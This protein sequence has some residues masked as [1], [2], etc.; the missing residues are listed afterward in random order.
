MASPQ[1]EHG[2]TAIANE[3][4]DALS[5]YRIPGEKRQVLDYI[6]RMTYGYNRKQI[7]VSYSKISI[8][9]HLHRQAVKRSV[10]WLKDNLVLKI[11]PAGTK[12]STRIAQTFVFNK[13]YEEWKQIEKKKSGNKNST[14]FG[15]KNSTRDPITPIIVKTKKKSDFLNFDLFWENYPIKVGKKKARQTWDKLKK[16]N[17]LPAIDKIIKAIKNQKAE[18]EYLQSQNKFCPEWK[19]PTTWLNNGCWD[20]EVKIPNNALP[21]YIYSAK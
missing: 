16:K 12:N 8:A 5:K 14:S 20:D 6:L 11:V 13:D 2:Y 21:G 19:H 15:N 9:T 3:I 17:E 1:R 18:K 10:S 4:M 7:T